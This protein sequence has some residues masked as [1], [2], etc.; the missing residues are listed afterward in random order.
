[1]SVLSI[2]RYIVY[3]Y[4]LQMIYCDQISTPKKARNKSANIPYVLESN[5]WLIV[6]PF[7]GQNQ[8]DRTEAAKFSRI[9]VKDLTIA[10]NLVTVN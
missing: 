7:F 9:M 3:Q 6:Q 5:L 8:V 2:I 1:M 4:C 10:N